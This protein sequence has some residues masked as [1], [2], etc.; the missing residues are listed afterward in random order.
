M[1]LKL[2][3]ENQLPFQ[4]DEFNTK[5]VR[6]VT[7]MEVR[8]NPGTTWNQKE[9]RTSVFRQT[10]QQAALEVSKE[11]IEIRETQDEREKEL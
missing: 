7:P 2:V 11:S 1:K 9:R 6:D 10:M 4:V 8:Q 3:L 5:E